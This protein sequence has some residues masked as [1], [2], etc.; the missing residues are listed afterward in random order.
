MKPSPRFKLPWAG[1]TPAPSTKR[2]CGTEFTPST[3]TVRVRTFFGG[4]VAVVEVGP[5]LVSLLIFRAAFFSH[6]DFVPQQDLVAV[7]IP[8]LGAVA[9]E[10]FSRWIHERHALRL[11]LLVL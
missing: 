8:K 1:V 3:R 6:R 7:G 10:I 5:S 2:R 4:E 11:Q 9:P